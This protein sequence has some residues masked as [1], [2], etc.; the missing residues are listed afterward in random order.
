M[1]KFLVR[2]VT[3]PFIALSAGVSTAFEI[4]LLASVIADAK[5]DPEKKDFLDQAHIKLILDPPRTVD[6]NR[7]AD[8]E[9]AADRAKTRGD[10]ERAIRLYGRAIRH[11]PHN[12]A[13][14]LLRGTVLL[15]VERPKVAAKDF[16]AGLELDPGNQTLTFLMHTANARA[17]AHTC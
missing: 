17:A 12:A 8:L 5:T 13:L 10:P 9:R 3:W 4:L 1:L 16:E 15:D 6:P 14:F 7:A 11:T 2:V